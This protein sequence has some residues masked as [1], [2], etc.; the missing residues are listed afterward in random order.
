[1][2]SSRACRCLSF[3]FLAAALTESTLLAQTVGPRQPPVSSRRLQGRD[4]DIIVLNGEDRLTILRRREGDVRVVFD[5]GRHWL[6]L[7][8]DYGSPSG[9]GPDGLVDWVYTFREISGE[10]PLGARWEGTSRVDEYSTAEGGTR[11]TTITT[12]AGL[13]ALTSPGL[14]GVFTLPESAAVTVTYKGSG[15]GTGGGHS[16]DDMEQRQI[17]DLAAH[18]G[19]PGMR[20]D[21]GSGVTAESRL[22]VTAPGAIRGRTSLPGGTRQPVKL[23]DV[24][25][26][27]PQTAR[28]AGI[29][30]TVLVQITIASDGAVSD[31]RVVRSIPGLDEAALA[32]VRQWRYDASS[33]TAG[34]P[35]ITLLVPV[36]FR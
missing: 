12:P 5:A 10:W 19:E 6:L 23:F 32:A 16:F 31:A 21:S 20:I 7:L 1:M 28:D 27:Y 15:R 33:L 29:T 26:V 8:A 13:V 36:P 24:K 3:A 4:G 17:A 30:G 14:P 11:A 25:P 35:P 22:T 18:G 9:G 34:G 2:T